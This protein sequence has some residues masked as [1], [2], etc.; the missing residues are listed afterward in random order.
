MKRFISIFLVLI[1][2][3]TT[4]APVWAADTE[5][6]AV[7]AS[8]RLKPL[9]QLGLLDVTTP[10]AQVSKNTI[11]NSIKTITNGSLD[12]T[13]TYFKNHDLSQ[14]LRYGQALMVL[15]DFLG[16]T[17]YMS[18]RGYN[19]NN[20]AEY[21]VAAKRIGLISNSK[22]DANA[23]L[24]AND[25]ADLLYN[26]VME[27]PLNKVIGVNKDNV[28][29]GIDDEDTALN[30]Y[31]KLE[32]IYGVVELYDVSGTDY[33]ATTREMQ[34][35]IGND[36]YQHELTSDLY[37]YFGRYAE[38]YTEKDSRK[39]KAIVPRED[40]NSE[41]VLSSDDFTINDTLTEIKYFPDENSKA[42]T[43]RL[44]S[45]HTFVFN[46]E[47]VI[48]PAKTDFAQPDTQ[49]KFIDNNDDRVFDVV[50]AEQF[51]SFII[52]SISFEHNTITD[53]DG[54]IYYLNDYFKE[55]YALYNKN[56][57]E[58]KDLSLLGRYYVV[59][60]LKAKS[61]Q[62]TYMTYSSE[63]VSGV[64]DRLIKES[65]YTSSGE[66]KLGNRYIVID[67][68]KYECAGKLIETF[69]K[70]YKVNGKEVKRE[71]LVNGD[72]VTVFFDNLGRIAEIEVNAARKK[73][74]FIFAYTPG[75]GFENAKV[76]LLTEDNEWKIATLRDRVYL[77]GNKVDAADVFKMNSVA[78][79]QLLDDEGKLRKQLIIVNIT[80]DN[81]ITNIDTAKDD[82]GLGKRGYNEFTLHYD[83]KYHS[84]DTENPNPR[85]EYVMIN[86]QKIAGTK[87]IMDSHCRSFMIF[88]EP[89][90]EHSFVGFAD[91]DNIYTQP[92]AQYFN[93]NDN[94]APEY[95]VNYRGKRINNW[96]DSYSN[97]FMVE[98]L[99][100]TVDEEGF[101]KIRLNYYDPS[102]KL[103]YTL[104][105][106]E[107]AEQKSTPSALLPL[108]K[109]QC[110]RI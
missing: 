92:A 20:S 51:T 86:G 72:N 41:L 98:S 50:I 68:V 81:I 13:D 40:Y 61:G 30:V 52:H 101:E 24:T 106:K 87:Y 33:T 69:E 25:Y 60:Y 82:R 32:R 29:Y 89:D 23:I 17:P 97:C 75:N 36:W 95:H 88:D 22:L 49:Y 63:K 48:G 15:I 45:V 62:M 85:L 16:Y 104:F 6:K 83:S 93:V 59:S 58:L 37:E 64:I 77:D 7:E 4:A 54:I 47:L 8:P 76:K 94:F 11:I 74:A 46:R 2:A 26:A 79:S 14:P 43:A 12:V 5:V 105:D 38:A 90:E 3:L 96:M 44:S 65:Y 9:N 42:K 110:S 102:G 100:E 109:I 55:G 84:A 57:K 99:E 10:D 53:T 107:Y 28:M 19:M 108:I 91:K 21:V 31:M 1:L 27:V 56:G 66:S 35:R 71:P 18:M 78:Q 39:I 70:G 80:E 73:A 34:I 103:L 67:G